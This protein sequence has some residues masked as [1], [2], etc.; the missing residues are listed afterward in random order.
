MITYVPAGTPRMVKVPSARAAAPYGVSS[1][2]T[3]EAIAGSS[4]E[5]R[6]RPETVPLQAS[7]AKETWERITA[8][9]SVRITSENFN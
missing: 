1:R 4:S 3:V 5:R 2:M 8:S 6:T 7:L 9:M